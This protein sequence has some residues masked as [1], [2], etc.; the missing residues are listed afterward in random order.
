MKINGKKARMLISI[1]DGTFE[2]IACKTSVKEFNIPYCSL[3]L[4]DSP[5]PQLLCY[6]IDIILRCF[7]ELIANPLNPTAQDNSDQCENV[8][9]LCNDL[10]IDYNKDRTGIC[11]YHWAQHENQ[12][13][14]CSC[15]D[16][17][18]VEQKPT[19][20]SAAKKVRRRSIRLSLIQRKEEEKCNRIRSAC[21]EMAGVER[22]V[23]FDQKTR[24]CTS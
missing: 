11:I 14:P 6:Q 8:Q 22:Q 24:L 12:Q 23:N 7:N 9:Y 13:D 18:E 17:T 19:S 4:V 20:P 16:E 15:D 3:K 2:R 5:T 21:M 1:G 10:F